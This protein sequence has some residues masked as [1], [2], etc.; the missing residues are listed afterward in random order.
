MKSVF[1]TGASG[2]GKSTT[3]NQ[4][5]EHGFT[6]SPNHLTR[7][8]RNGERH[9]VDAHFLSSGAFEQ[10]FADGHY[11]EESLEQAN[12]AGCY[13]GSPAHWYTSVESGN[14]IIAVPSNVVVLSALCSRLE[15]NDARSNLLWVNLFAPYETRKGRIEH[16]IADLALLE[17]R[18]TSGVSHG[19][20]PEADLNIDTSLHHPEVVASQIL[21]L[22]A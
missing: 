22:A 21:E 11:L 20:Q 9:G 16:R 8:P 13:Y 7:D 18:L 17:Q 10:N 14:P 15:Q 4:L 1:L 12:Y 19:F 5:L 3:Y 2:V 6:P